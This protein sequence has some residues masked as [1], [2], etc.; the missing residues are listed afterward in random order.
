MSLIKVLT[1]L[2]ILLIA[3]TVHSLFFGADSKTSF[4]TLQNENKLLSD[5]NNSLKTEN[6]FLESAI[7]S[8]QQNDLYAEKFA[9]EELNLIMQGEEFISFQETN[10]DEPQ[11]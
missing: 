8:K 5:A 10:A 1:W 3:V 6:N 9:R 11:Q 2:L 7:K 4:A